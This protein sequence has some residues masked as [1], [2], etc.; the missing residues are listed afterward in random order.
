[1]V[2]LQT[3]QSTMG[4][5]PPF[6]QQHQGSRS[7]DQ[8]SQ[9]SSNAPAKD[10]VYGR[11]KA[12]HQAETLNG[13]AIGKD[14]NSGGR[15]R[16]EEDEDEDDDAPL[17]SLPSR[18]GGARSQ[19]GSSYGGYQQQPSFFPHPS[20]IGGYSQLHSAPPGVDPYLYAS[21]P[22]D[23]KMGL[24]HR[25]Q[26]M[27][28]MMAQAAEQA[29]AES[30]AG[31]ESGSITGSDGRRGSR[32]SGSRSGDMSMLG[33]GGMSQS[34]PSMGYGFG[35]PMTMPGGRLPPFAPSMQM[36]QTFFNEQ[37]PNPYYAGSAM[38]YPGAQ[39]AV[40]APTGRSGGG[41]PRGS[42]SVI[43]TGRR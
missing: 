39:S 1:M 14:L 11:M 31:W 22:P 41:Q 7:V 24:H 35:Y 29:K 27:M 30:T 34:M 9:M 8:L 15:L 6:V 20:S 33:G 37:P 13:L 43:G 2:S 25:A 38:G 3:P 4:R 40:G 17:A 5:R 19:A 26:Q 18:G 32:M 42:A 23:Q 12:R 36:S 10:D 21:L 16:D 28:A